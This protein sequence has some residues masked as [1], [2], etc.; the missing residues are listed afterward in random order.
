[1]DVV[2][3]LRLSLDREGT[4]LGVARQEAECRAYAEARGWTVT[5]TYVDNDISATTGRR[6]PAFEELLEDAPAVV[7]VWHNDRL[8]RLSRDLERVLD[9][10]LTVHAVTAG[11]F[12]LSTPTGRAM[13]RT[14]VAWSTY[15][16]EHRSERQRAQAYQRAQLGRPF[17]SRRPFGFNT[18]GTHRAEE[19]EAIRDAYAAVLQGVARHAIAKRWNA[20][21]LTTAGK[22]PKP[23]TSNLVRFILRS[24]R[25]IAIREYKGKEVGPGNWQPIVDRETWDGVQAIL[26]HDAATRRQG[27]PVGGLLSG[28]ALCGVCGSVMRGGGIVRGQSTYICRRQGCVANV[29]RDAVDR[30][31]WAKVVM[32]VLP[33]RRTVWSG[34]E[35]SAARKSLAAKIAIIRGKLTTAAEMWSE[36]TITDDQLRV[37]TVQLKA[38]AADLKAELDAIPADLAPVINLTAADG[39]EFAYVTPGAVLF[40]PIGTT[41]DQCR[42]V[43]RELAVVTC[44]PRGKGANQPYEPSAYITVEPVDISAG[45]A[46]A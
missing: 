6:R 46:V 36:G 3:Y 8:V 25:N 29:P 34:T 11:E 31:V 26:D 4:G 42:R 16:G 21:G 28:I 14:L 9:L 10:G 24:P 27:R 12:D 2:L 32:D 1:M 23:W 30:Y 22:Q 17:W 20:Q 7:L 15:E 38:Q 5:K 44:Q 13:A 18:D 37:T 39:S 43:L 41:L 19:A 40:P 33:N 45:T 35:H